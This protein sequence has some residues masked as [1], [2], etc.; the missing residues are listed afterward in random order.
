M[1]FN[2]Q[3]WLYDRYNF[4]V[5]TAPVGE[6]ISL[7]EARDHLRIIAFG[8]PPEH[9]EDAWITRNISVAREWCEGWAGRSFCVQ[10]LELGIQMF[11]T[12]W[13]HWATHQIRWAPREDGILLPLAAPFIS[14]VSVKYDDGSGM[15][16][17]L[18]PSAYYV[19]DYEEPA[20]LYPT[21]GTSWPVAQLGK[22]GAVRVRYV[23]GYSLEGSS[24]MLTRAIPFRYKAAMLLVLGHLHENREDV[25]DAQLHQIPNGAASLLG[26]NRLRLGMA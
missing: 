4:K 21:P 8:S 9:E 6:H 17:T 20:T 25:T 22:R 14:L 5:I 23:C 16:Q 19:N 11:P 26:W 1:I 18:D 12:T 10:T 7:D 15:E 13:N 24:P 2:P 3:H